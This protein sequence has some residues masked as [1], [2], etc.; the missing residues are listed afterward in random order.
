MTTGTAAQQAIETARRL[1]DPEDVLAA[2]PAPA[3]A[4]LGGGLAGTALLHA[5]LSATDPLFAAAATRHWA[6]AAAH[7]KHHR[8]GRGIFSGTGG[9]ATSLITGTGYLPDPGPQQHAATRAAQWLSE[10][11]I[12]ISRRH[13][14]QTQT[15]DLA[16]PWAV[17]DVV[18][19]LSGVGR[20]LLTAGVSG[21]TLAEPG[22]LAALKTLTTMIHTRQHNR[23]GW[24][25]PADR[26]PPGVSLHPS[27]AATTGMAHGIAGPLALL[28]AAHAAGWNVP[29]QAAAIKEAAQWLLRWHDHR[30]CSWPP[31]ITGDEL[32]SGTADPAPGR[33]DAWCY[34]TPGISRALTLAGRAIN[35]APLAQAG[36]AAIASLA[37]RRAQCWDVE[38]PTLC[39]GAAGVLQSAAET[40]AA[41]RYRAAAAVTAAYDPQQKFAFQH[42]HD[43]VTSDMPGLLTGAAGVALALA[44]HAAMPAPA[45]P[46]RWDSILLLS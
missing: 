11:A 31:H 16:T 36:E 29:G 12:D 32:D 33:R 17:Y 35:D 24:W 41:T 40:G 9:L 20:V 23:P 26:H 27:G 3:A 13:Q 37:A 7:A 44:D 46:A 28:S 39:H 6:T 21:H 8:A 22:L 43:N 25:L 34:G 19:G 4:S 2:I 14:T 10:H 42:V 45:V 15:G 18:S 5:R 30:T 1:L 38:G